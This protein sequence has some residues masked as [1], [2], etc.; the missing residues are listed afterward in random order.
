M[1]GATLRP[2]IYFRKTKSMAEPNQSVLPPSG[3][4]SVNPD[5]KS[6][7]WGLAAISNAGGSVVIVG[8]G[9]AK[10]VLINMTNGWWNV[11][12]F[13]SAG[14]SLGA[15][16]AIT[17]SNPSA[18]AEFTTSTALGFD[19]FNSFGSMKG[20]ELTPLI[21]GA[22]S[23]VNIWSVDHSP[24]PID[25][26]GLQVGLSGGAN[27]VPGRFRVS[28]SLFNRGGPAQ[29]TSQSVTSML[30]NTDVDQ[31]IAAEIQQGDHPQWA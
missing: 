26:G 27:W 19:D 7:R 25:V 1:V 12:F 31:A 13:I 11:Y 23:Y 30:S 18:P 16:L 6:A 29:T 17:F 15:D 2:S 20:V 14:I 10:F 21:G 28:T 8:A 4:M 5:A 24:N 9:V 22:L 3:G